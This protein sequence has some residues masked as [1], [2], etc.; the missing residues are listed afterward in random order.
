MSH[1]MLTLS[2][3]EVSNDAMGRTVEWTLLNNDGAGC[4]VS[5]VESTPGDA[6]TTCRAFLAKTNEHG[7]CEI[8]CRRIEAE[9][10]NPDAAM[11][12]NEVLGQLSDKYR[13]VYGIDPCQRQLFPGEVVA[14]D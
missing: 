2:E 11:A 13:Y 10:H 6:R 4:M 9:S 12:L 8:T 14:D 7:K 3:P 1:E 5:W